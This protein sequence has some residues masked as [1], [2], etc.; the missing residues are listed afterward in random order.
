MDHT[1]N[2]DNAGHE[3]YPAHAI[4]SDCSLTDEDGVH[5]LVVD[6]DDLIRR[7]VVEVL[8]DAGHTVYDAARGDEGVKMAQDRHPD[9]V[10]MDLMLPGINGV[11]ATRR[12]KQDHDTCD[13]RVIAM[14]AVDS[15]T[16]RTPLLADA[17]LRKPFDIDDLLSLVMP[18]QG[19]TVP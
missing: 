14:S 7:L 15:R 4:S 10:V 12:L 9:V 6:D 5:V 8:R 13:I 11:E 3:P 2:A 16:F 1:M 19:S 17:F 18:S